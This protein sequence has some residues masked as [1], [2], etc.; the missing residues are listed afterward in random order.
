M[1]NSGS[2]RLCVFFCLLLATV[3]AGAQVPEAAAVN[4]SGVVVDETAA[5]VRDAAVLILGTDLSDVTDADG[6]FEIENVPAGSWTLEA[7]LPGYTIGT[8]QVEVGDQAI[9]GL[10]VDLIA[11]ETPLDEIIVTASHSI[12]R[13]EPTS[14]V[15]LGRE[16]LEKLPHFGDDLYR[17]ITVLPG[18]SGGNISAAFNV[19]GGFHEELLARVDGQEV[20]EPFHLKDF[21]GVFSIL[22]PQIISSVDLVPGGFSAEFGDRMTAVLDMRTIQPT[23][24]RTNLGVS[25]SNFWVGNAGTFADGKGRWLG[26]ARRGF[27]DLVLA[28]SEDSEEDGDEDITVRYWDL[29]GK[30]DYAITP[31]QR[32]GLS[33]L[34]AEDTVDFD[35]V[36]DDEKANVETSYGNS[37]IWADHQAFLGDGT[38][39]DTI[40]SLGSIDRDR[41]AILSEERPPE[42]ANIL[43]VRDTELLTLK[44][45]WGSQLGDRHLLKW[46]FEARRWEADYDYHNEA[47]I[48]DPIDDPRFLPGDR[49]TD[50]TD[51]YSSEQYS[52]YLADRVRLGDKLTAEV[53]L[54]W[55]RVTLTEEDYASPRVA[56]VYD[57]GSAGILRGGW[58][59]FYQSQRPYE[60][61][62]QFGETDFQLSARAEHYTLGYENLLGEY[63]VRADVYRRDVTDAQIRY[64]TLF[65]PFNIFPEVRIDLVAIPAETATA[66]G[67]EVSLRSPMRP[68]IN[69]WL[70]YSWSQVED[71][72]MGRTIPRRIDQTHALTT[73]L[74]WRPAEKWSLTWVWFFHTGWPTTPVS[75]E[76]V[77]P[78]GEFPHLSYDVGEFYSQRFDDYRRLDF[79]VSRR[80]KVGKDGFLTFFLDVQNLFDRANQRGIEIG[81]PDVS[82]GPDGMLDVSFP[83]EDWLPILPSFGVTWEF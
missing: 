50:F 33:V 16:Q 72:V 80:S 73:S 36:D 78:P 77:F 82:L 26:S 14:M 74:S 6:F 51:D 61:A 27:L 31:S 30:I 29:F 34:A 41:V 44:Q 71:E 18:V 7:R 68:K 46:G 49:L 20:I 28:L 8:L 9:T 5:P 48:A 53:G 2:K 58:G 4:V 24:L 47:M 75:A 38:F 25:F 37:Y 15:G 64:E 1:T 60:L 12:R 59:L 39:V 70:T 21:Q 11:V 76:V 43:D 19:R 40:L 57:L 81:D 45:D 3:A 54:R 56:L 52:V 23:E 55:D 17:A 22:D 13:D 79:R 63:R 10:E 32:L 69:W 83:I 67:V 65:D 42:F 35:E 62:V 66:D